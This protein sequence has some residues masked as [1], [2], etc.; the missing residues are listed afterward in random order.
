MLP[1]SRAVFIARF[2][3]IKGCAN[4]HPAAV[5][6]FDQLV[7]D[8]F[9]Y[10]YS[11]HFLT[12]SISSISTRYLPPI[13]FAASRILMQRSVSSA[14][15]KARRIAGAEHPKVSRI[16]RRMPLVMIISRAIFFFLFLSY[17]YF[18]NTF[19]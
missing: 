13:F 18:F 3:E 1:S 9:V 19:A 6:L 15:R 17:P 7:S 8:F 11:S 12:P 10:E 4:G 16:F 14:P 2:S 5:E